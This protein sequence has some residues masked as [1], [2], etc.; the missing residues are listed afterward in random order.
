MSVHVKRRSRLVGV[1]LALVSFVVA[2][3]KINGA[4]EFQANGDMKFDFTFEDSRDTMAKINRT[5]ESVETIF[6]R[7]LG[8][9]TPLRLRT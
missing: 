9:L 6:W 5:C 1:V 4:V 8:L 2:G 3:C 7:R